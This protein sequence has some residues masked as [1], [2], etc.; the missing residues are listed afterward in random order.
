MAPLRSLL[1]VLWSGDETGGGP[2]VVIGG[3][4]GGIYASSVGTFKGV[5][6]VEGALVG[7]PLIRTLVVL[8]TSL[9][10]TFRATVALW[11]FLVICFTAMI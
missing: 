9:V 2:S 11:I 3:G 10:A 7:G 6:E 1:E 8:G 4:G 5:L